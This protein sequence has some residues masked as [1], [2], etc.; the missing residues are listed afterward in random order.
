MNKLYKMQNSKS[1]FDRIT[2]QRGLHLKKMAK[3]FIAIWV[4]L[5]SISLSSDAQWM[6]IDRNGGNPDPSA[7]LEVS[8]TTRGFLPPRLTTTQM[9]AISAPASGLLIFNTTDSTYKYFN[10]DNWRD[11]GNGVSSTSTSGLSYQEISH[12]TASYSVTSLRVKA[13]DYEFKGDSL[14]SVDNSSTYSAFIAREDLI[15]NVTSSF[16]AGTGA[17]GYIRVNDV[18]INVGSG[19]GGTWSGTS[20]PL[21]IEKDDTITIHLNGTPTGTW[22]LK[23]VALSIQNS[24]GSSSTSSTSV[25]S[26]DES[27]IV[28]IKDVKSSGAQSGTFTSGTW[29]IRDLNTLEGDTSFVT[30]STNEFTLDGGVYSIEW[31]APASRVSH[32]KSRLYNVTDGATEV[33]GSSAFTATSGG[34]AS[35]FSVGHQIIKLSNTLTFRVEHK[36]S[37]TYTLSGFGNY[38]NLGD[39]VF[40]QVKITKLDKV[41]GAGASASTNS[42]DSSN[43]IIDADGDTWVETDSNGTDNDQIRMYLDSNERY[44]FVD[45]RLEMLNGNGLVAIGQ[46]A[47]KLDNRS[48]ANTYY[49]TNAGESNVSGVAVTAIGY[50]SLT[51]STASYNTAMGYGSLGNNTTGV[52]N[53]VIGD[54]S[55]TASNASGITAVGSASLYKNTTGDDNTAIGRYALEENLTGSQNTALGSRSLENGTIGNLN[56]GVGYA[57]LN[58]NDSGA[59]NVAVG[60]NAMF[61]NSNGAGNVSLGSNSMNASI[62]PL[63]S[64]AIGENSLRNSINPYEIVALGYRA[65]GN[66]TSGSYNVAVG[67]AAGEDNLTGSGNVFLG[68]R[69]GQGETGSNRL[70]IENDSN[71]TPLIY[72][73]FDN[74]KLNLNGKVMLGNGFTGALSSSNTNQLNI[75]SGIDVNG[76]TNGIR[77]LETA[78]FGMSFGYDGSGFGDT[79][80]LAAYNSSG[81]SIMAFQNGGHIGIGTTT[82]AELLTL[83][84]GGN[85]LLIDSTSN[86]PG[87]IIFQSSTSSQLGRIWSFDNVFNFSSFDNTPDLSIDSTG[88]IGIHTTTP[89]GDVSII[90]NSTN[91]PGI[92]LQGYGNSEGDIAVAEGEALQIGHWNETTS[93]Y[94]GRIHIQADGDVGIGTSSPNEEL[95]VEG[96][97]QIDGEYKYESAKTKYLAISNAAFNYAGT[98][99][100][101]R[102]NRDLISG[103]NVRVRTSGGSAGNDAKLNAPVYLPDGA[104]VTSVRAV[105]FDANGTYNSNIRLVRQLQTSTTATTMAV[106]STSGSGGV[107][108]ITDGTISNATIDNAD[109]LYTLQFE[110]KEATV[111]IALYSVR[112]TYT[113]TKAE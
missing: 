71:S 6:K 49:G 54:F 60:A 42:S 103:F 23:M 63:S 111:N 72:G 8:D 43:I 86:D 12:N 37:S 96:D 47:G 15:V 73:E 16:V 106:A 85:L 25:S 74:D 18:S 31:L 33:Y 34:D 83:A 24:G 53:V 101:V 28:L 109:Y 22:Y 57:A 46:D 50:N 3:R 59:S 80:F 32:H 108:T 13:T 105:V 52:D 10:G 56:V 77:F 75:L 76:N 107:Q 40:T 82:P 11:L 84:K 1:L 35:N 7:A 95:D 98:N 113:V 20:T 70:Y 9:N 89:P 19:S 64:V 97:I 58:S 39:E 110:T 36:C 112:I 14:L 102:E 27:G 69:S 65:L 67:F 29:Q 94:T 93:T 30:L 55:A 48:N 68:H 79:N 26:V 81:N 66:Q 62:T 88:N 38:G 100:A 87:D 99:T 90:S 4:L 21:F 51:N 91:D 17:Y 92:Y 41:F 2:L 61:S 5:V 78:F 44:R 104:I 45:G